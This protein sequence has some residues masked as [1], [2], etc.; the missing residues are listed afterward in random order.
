MNDKKNDQKK[1]KW[2]NE[3]VE[4]ERR[5]FIK[6]FNSKCLFVY[7]LHVFSFIHF[8]V[9]I[10]LNQI[11]VVYLVFFHFTS[12]SHFFVISSHCHLISSVI[13]SHLSSH[14]ICHLISFV[15]SSHL[16]SHLIFFTRNKFAK[17]CSRQCIKQKDSSQ[18][19][20]CQNDINQSRINQKSVRQKSINQKNEESNH[21]W[22]QKNRWKKNHLISKRWANIKLLTIYC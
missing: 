5:L 6:T 9:Y 13:S 15:I 4:H 17:F 22:S 21:Q 16:S 8:L 20:F 19:N 11:N 1:F 7:L 14:L 18:K 2:W 12:S 10:S 3:N